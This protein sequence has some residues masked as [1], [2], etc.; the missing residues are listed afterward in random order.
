MD[1]APAYIEGLVAERHLGWAALHGM[2]TSAWKFIDAPRQELYDLTADGAEATNRIDER[3]DVA[4]ALR[5]KLDASRNA[6]PAGPESTR[7]D[8]EATTRLRA[9]GYLG[10]RGP[11]VAQGKPVDRCSGQ[12]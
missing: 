10:G 4:D 11:D 1:D 5:A 6:Q 2:R 8:A 9:L 12:T 3:R 7:P